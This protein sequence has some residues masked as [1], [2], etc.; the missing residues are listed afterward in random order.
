MA[1][2]RWKIGGGRRRSPGRKA[3]KL[4][5]IMLRHIPARVS[6]RGCTL[7]AGIGSGLRSHNGRPEP[8]LVLAV[9]KVKELTLTPGQ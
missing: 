3:S 9:M 6:A 2:S 5:L 1:M 8:E 4:A 7:C